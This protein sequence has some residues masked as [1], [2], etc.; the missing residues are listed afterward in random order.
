MRGSA[1]WRLAGRPWG[2]PRWG[3]ATTK[4]LQRVALT[5]LIC[6]VTAFVVLKVVSGQITDDTYTYI[7]AGERLNAGHPL[8]AL[9]PGD[10]PVQLYP[11]FWTVPL[12]S[13]PFI[14]VVWRPLA[15]IP[16]EL[17][18]V[19]WLGGAWACLILLL[20][21]LFRRA[22]AAS[23]VLA[24]TLVF[25]LF[26]EFGV[27]NVNPYLYAGLLGTW[28]L[29][30]DQR[31]GWAGGLI[32]VLAAL[33]LTPAIFLVWL[34]CCYGRRGLAGAAVGLLLCGLVS[35]IGAGLSSHLQYLS[36]AM[37][38]N[39]AGTTALSIA[40]LAHEIG[41]PASIA[42]RLPVLSLGVGV[43]G[44]W[45]L[46]R[47]PGAG[48]RLAA[49]TMLVGT[50]VVYINTFCILLLLLV[51]NAFPLAAPEGSTP[52]HAAT[53]RRGG[54]VVA[55]ALRVAL[56]LAF[57]LVGVL[58]WST[59]DVRLLAGRAEGLFLVAGAVL[60]TGTGMAIEASW[61]RPRPEPNRDDEVAWAS[62]RAE[63]QA[64]G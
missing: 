28:L 43:V 18:A 39:T 13:P 54:A 50:P 15:A 35:I 22:G 21:A 60:G 23:V 17:G 58:V 55:W 29:V 10:R 49:T 40:G 8:Y 42:A 44:L 20:S 56:G 6:C 61:W 2:G 33:K 1:G 14:A 31:Y 19:V 3:P 36:I 63:D 47:R 5:L 45:L 41:A 34:V 4:E 30:R 25:S 52:R 57:A 11:P 59:F 7:A 62:G 48:Y 27:G 64:V 12:L 38:T 51:P 32:A 9:S 16:W 24:G 26:Y 46:R 37:D 53:T